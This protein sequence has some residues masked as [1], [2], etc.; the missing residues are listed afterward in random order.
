M[1][2]D[3]YSVFSELQAMGVYDY[4]LPFLLMFAITFAILEKLKIFG[5]KSNIN[6]LVSL[7]M[8]LVLVSRPDITFMINN[9]IPKISLFILVILMFLIVFGIFGGRT[10]GW[11]SYGIIIALVVCIVAVIWAL[12]PGGLYGLPY[13]LRP[14]SRDKAWIVLLITIVVA[15]AFIKGKGNDSESSLD[16]FLK[17]ITKSRGNG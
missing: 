8:G 7:I 3:F 4:V 14:D 15:I 13:W 9:F 17:G 16:K 10:E 5:D 11:E 1:P 6:L 2:V 12:Y